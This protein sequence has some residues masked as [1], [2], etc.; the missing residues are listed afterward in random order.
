MDALETLIND[1]EKDTEEAADMNRRCIAEWYTATEHVTDE[2]NNAVFNIRE[3][4]WAPQ[5]N[6]RRINLL[7][8][9]LR[10]LYAKHRSARSEPAA[11]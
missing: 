1:S 11:D 10:E 5:E 8:L 2:I 9:R 6:F 3:P 7:K 4:R